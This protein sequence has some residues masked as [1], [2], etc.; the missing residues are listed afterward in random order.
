MRRDDIRRVAGPGRLASLGAAG[1]TFAVAAVVG[2][3]ALVAVLGIAALAPSARAE[4]V[5]PHVSRPSAVTSH[6]VDPPSPDNGQ[7]GG[8][9]TITAPE[10]D[11]EP[12]QFVQCPGGSTCPGRSE[13]TP[14]EEGIRTEQHLWND[15]VGRIS[16]PL[17]CPYFTEL[18]RPMDIQ[19]QIYQDAGLSANSINSID[20]D[21]LSQLLSA[22][23]GFIRN[24]FTTREP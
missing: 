20:P 22:S 6:V 21:F 16:G 13:P 8:Q 18:V 4:V 19:L 10:Q 2:L 9:A 7:G 17:L 1:G 12:V 15:F 24:C 3:A 23:I 5:V 14:Q 11:S